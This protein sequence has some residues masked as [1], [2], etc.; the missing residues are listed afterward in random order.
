MRKLNFE[1]DIFKSFKKSI[2]YNFFS[3]IYKCLKIYLWN[4]IEKIRKTTK[5]AR[6]R[7]QNLSKEEKGQ[8]ATIWWWTS[9]KS[10]RR[11]KKINW[12]STEQNIIEWEKTLCYNYNL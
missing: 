6:E 5:K 7:Y 10:L 12:L 2:F 9:Q 11:W 1:S 4:I 8:K 3:Y